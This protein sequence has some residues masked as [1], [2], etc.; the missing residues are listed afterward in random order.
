MK[1]KRNVTAVHLL[2]LLVFIGY[3]VYVV[4]KSFDG[5]IYRNKLS[6]LF[7]L[8]F[9]LIM[10]VITSVLPIRIIAARSSGETLI[11]HLSV[12]PFVYLVIFCILV[13]FS[14]GSHSLLNLML[15][16]SYCIFC[17]YSLV[18]IRKKAR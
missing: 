14:I 2:T 7:S 17:A 15:P 13:L 4:D 5:L 6:L 11:K 8:V 1:N 10:S 16:L 3:T 18:L 12:I 9:V